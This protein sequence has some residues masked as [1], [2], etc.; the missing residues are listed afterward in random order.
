MYMYIYWALLLTWS[1]R[2]GI[3]VVTASL[4]GSTGSDSKL[5]Q[6]LKQRG[7][8]TGHFLLSSAERAQRV[9]TEEPHIKGRI[10]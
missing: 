7:N 1:L 4:T 8:K 3:L 5:T 2:K 10:S 6:A 9:S